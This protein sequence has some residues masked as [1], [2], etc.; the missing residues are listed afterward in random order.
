MCVCFLLKPRCRGLDN[1]KTIKQLKR[2][3]AGIISASTSQHVVVTFLKDSQIS[4]KIKFLFPCVLC[5][6]NMFCLIFQSNF[7]QFFKCIFCPVLNA[8]SLSCLH[9]SSIVS[10]SMFSI[11]EIKLF[12]YESLSFKNVKM[13]MFM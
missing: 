7:T 4:R 9:N 1:L 5:Y 2:E 13:F 10:R 8:F 6:L 11:L 12:F 3:F